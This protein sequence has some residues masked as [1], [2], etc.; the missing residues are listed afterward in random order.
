MRAGRAGDPA[1]R[2]RAWRR[3]VV[4]READPMSLLSADAISLSFGGIRAVDRLSFDVQPGEV[5]SII[6]PNGAG[7]TSIFNL[8]SRLY[9]LETGRLSFGGRD[10]GRLEPHE[11]ASAGIARTFQ[12]IRLFDQASVLTNLMLGRYRHNRASVLA[13]CLFLPA[14]RRQVLADREKVEQTID[15]LKI[16][17]YRDKRAGDLSY[18]VRKIVELGRALVSE[19]SLLLLDEPSSGLSPEETLGMVF[20]VEDIRDKLGITVMMIEHDM[21]LVSSVSS[22][23]LAVNQ[24]SRLALGTAAEVQSDPAVIAA[25]LGQATPGRG[26]G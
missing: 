18:G 5:F 23:V 15:F 12:N 25:Y 8:I 17:R 6:G 22:R 13:Q 3:R 11:V 24:G 7:K 14:A 1:C 9:P 10:L 16:E 2:S 19:P 4:R 21:S 26:P 20:W